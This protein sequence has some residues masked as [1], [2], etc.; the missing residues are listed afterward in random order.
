MVISVTVQLLDQDT[1]LYSPD[2]AAAQVLAALG[3]NSTK[4]S[5]NV[6]ISSA[7]YGSA[8]TPPPPP[9]LHTQADE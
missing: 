3:A 2:A 6:S 1:L 5:C 8:G 7:T 4:D 9:V